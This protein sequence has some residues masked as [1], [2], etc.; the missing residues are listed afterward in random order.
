[1]GPLKMAHLNGLSV[2][3]Q[4]VYEE[5]KDDPE[6]ASNDERV[7]REFGIGESVVV[8]SGGG[9]KLKLLCESRCFQLKEIT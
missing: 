9:G 3:R 1:M 2:S 6:R 8:C 4:P 7:R 5:A